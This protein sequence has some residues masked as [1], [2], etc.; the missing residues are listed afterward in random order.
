MRSGVVRLVHPIAE[1]R[2]VLE[3]RDRGKFDGA[4]VPCIGR[5]RIGRDAGK[6]KGVA[7]S[8]LRTGRE[9]TA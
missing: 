2:V 9:R 4:P 3:I 8:R 7:I 5:S 6:A 1:V